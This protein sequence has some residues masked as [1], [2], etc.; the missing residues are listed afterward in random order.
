VK[1]CEQKHCPGNIDDEREEVKNI[2]NTIYISSITLCLKKTT[3]EAVC[4]ARWK[5]EWEN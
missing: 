4:I 2:L 3:R 1:T 5:R